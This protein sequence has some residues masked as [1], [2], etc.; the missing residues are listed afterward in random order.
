VPTEPLHVQ[1]GI[2][3]VQGSVTAGPPSDGNLSASRAADGSPSVFPR[4]PTSTWCPQVCLP[5]VLQ[6]QNRMQTLVA[7]SMADATAEETVG[8][9]FLEA[10]ST[11]AAVVQSR[12]TVLGTKSQ[13]FDRAGKM[14]TARD[15]RNEEWYYAQ[16]MAAGA[17]DAHVMH[18][19]ESHHIGRMH[20][21]AEISVAA[22][23]RK[24]RETRRASTSN[25]GGICTSCSGDEDSD[26]GRRTYHRVSAVSV[27]PSQPVLPGLRSS[28][29]LP[30]KQY[31]RLVDQVCASQRAAGSWNCLA[32]IAALAH[33]D[34]DQVVVLLGGEAFT[35]DSAVGQAVG[36]LL[37]MHLLE[38]QCAE[39][40]GEWA[41]L[42]AKAQRWLGH[43]LPGALRAS[44]GQSVAAQRLLAFVDSGD[45]DW[46]QH[47]QRAVLGC[48]QA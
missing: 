3:T 41:L 46:I 37:A 14:K 21:Q 5:V 45:A 34:L 22:V 23:D 38:A 6:E 32:E 43:V 16:S 47:A 15:A 4:A 17:A 8:E 12:S 13:V 42:G 7:A 10:L 28:I 35:P 20:P 33:V 24:S 48:H 19:V 25:C 30:P 2:S 39:Q 9:R 11:R 1:T 44:A 40:R 26:D 29:L 18:S 27:L 31:D 36:T